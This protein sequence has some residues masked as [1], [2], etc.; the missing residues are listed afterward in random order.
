[1]KE[2]VPSYRASSESTVLDVAQHPYAYVVYDGG[3]VLGGGTTTCDLYDE[4]AMAAILTPGWGFAYR[5][6]ARG[7][8]AA[9]RIRLTHRTTGVVLE[10]RADPAQADA[11][12]LLAAEEWRRRDAAEVLRLSRLDEDLLFRAVALVVLRECAPDAVVTFAMGVPRTASQLI[13]EVTRGTDDG[14]VC[15]GCLAWDWRDALAVRIKRQP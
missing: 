14:V 11:W 6:H 12:H 3:K 13:D 5:H 2:L 10:C 4:G 9:P 8:A 7:V 15:A 1:M